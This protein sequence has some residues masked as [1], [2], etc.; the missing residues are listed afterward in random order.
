V[1]VIGHG[2]ND[3]G[4]GQGTQTVLQITGPAGQAIV[5]LEGSGK[6]DVKDLVK[7]DS[8]IPPSH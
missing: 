1:K 8:L 5:H 2:P 4:F 6:L 7:H 3:P